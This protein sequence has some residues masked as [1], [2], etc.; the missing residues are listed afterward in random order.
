MVLEFVASSSW[1]WVCDLSMSACV[2]TLNQV[3][4][5]RLVPSRWLLLRFFSSYLHNL[6]SPALT[7]WTTE[8]KW[9][10]L[11]NAV[12]F[13][14]GRAEQAWLC[15]VRCEQYHDIFL[16]AKALCLGQGGLFRCTA[17]SCLETADV[18][19]G[20]C[21]LA[22]ASTVVVKL[23]YVFRL[24]SCSVWHFA[25]DFKIGLLVIMGMPWVSGSPHSVLLGRILLACPGESSLV[26]WVQFWEGR[27]LYGTCFLLCRT[28]A[29]SYSSPTL[30]DWGDESLSLPSY[31]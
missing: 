22:E 24:C 3:R 6:T 5:P 21:Y 29:H 25:R 26:A 1:K 17:V 27:G 16:F 18:R 15:A 2:S 8:K 31:C 11:C 10:K 20:S 19:D 7:G 12:V 9:H 23:L 4:L 28:T 30:G 13:L 14:L